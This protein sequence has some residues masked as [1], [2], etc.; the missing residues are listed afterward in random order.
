EAKRRLEDKDGVAATGFGFDELA[1]G[2]AAD[3]LVG[4]PEENDALAEWSFSLL[5]GL[6]REERLH[7]SG[8]HIERAGT[9][10]SCRGD[11]KGHFREGAGGV[12]GVIVAEDEELSGCARLL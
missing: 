8:F 10:S 11:A 3:F 1:G 9:V 5:Q 12:D 2:V 6:E 4:R 7:D